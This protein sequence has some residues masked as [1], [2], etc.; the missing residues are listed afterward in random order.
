MKSNQ[1]PK[2]TGRFTDFSGE[3]GVALHANNPA[4]SGA[5]G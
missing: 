4:K 5:T 1:K 3:P 2:T